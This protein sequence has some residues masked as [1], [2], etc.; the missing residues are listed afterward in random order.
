MVKKYCFRSVSVPFPMRNET[1]GKDGKRIR[2]ESEEA[3][4]DATISHCFVGVI[5]SRE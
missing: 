5:A 2:S 1:N 4:S 3:S